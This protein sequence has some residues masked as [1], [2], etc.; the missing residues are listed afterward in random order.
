MSMKT[1]IGKFLPKGGKTRFF[2]VKI[3]FGKILFAGKNTFC[4]PHD[5]GQSAV[6]KEDYA[7]DKIRAAILKHGT[8][9]AVEGD[10]LHNVITHAYIPDEYVQA[11]LNADATGQ[12]LYKDYVSDRIN[13]DVSLWAPVK[14]ENN[15][16]LMS[17]NKKTTIK[18]RDKTVDLKETKDLY[19]R[20]MV[21]ARSSRD[22]NHAERGHWEL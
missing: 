3:R 4:H 6:K 8:P 18:L 13:E 11:I 9:F 12:T 5:L 10:K 15:K 21:L 17:A 14:K 22:I 1:R 20:L 7:I 16:M 19:G 2:H